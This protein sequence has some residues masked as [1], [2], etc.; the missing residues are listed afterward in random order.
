MSSAVQ[1]STPATPAARTDDTVAPESAK[2]LFGRMR[3][4]GFDC[5]DI[6]KDVNFQF[7]ELDQGR[8][9][10][11]DYVRLIHNC[12]ELS[13]EPDLGLRIGRTVRPPEYGLF[14]YALL[15]NS[16]LQNSRDFAVRYFSMT[17]TMM[18]LDYAGEGTDVKLLP[19]TPYEFSP[20]VYRY[21]VD[22]T[23]AAIVSIMRTTTHGRFPLSE[24]R[25]A[26]DRPANVT[27][28]EKA[29]GCPVVFGCVE[30]ALLVSAELLSFRPPGAD[31]AAERLLAEQCEEIVAARRYDEENFLDKVRAVIVRR[32]GK[33]LS[34]N[35]VARRLAMSA[36]GMKRRLAAAGSS[37]QQLVDETR[38]ELARDLFRRPEITIEDAAYLCGYENPASFRRAFKRWTGVT[39]SQ[40]RQR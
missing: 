9:Y 18:K 19:T 23:M 5:H 15:T 17:G 22:F 40:Y 14:G 16:Q 3:E 29:Y 8:G 28:Y 1:R 27:A 39:A 32:P 24:T 33:P 20:A 12:L 6:C 38:L 4:R 37:Y 25:F 7:A 21:V 30:N 31:P 10:V 26:I 34:L 11:S 2:I 35:E 13:G 36:S